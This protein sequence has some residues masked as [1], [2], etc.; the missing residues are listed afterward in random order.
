MQ[1]IFLKLQNKWPGKIARISNHVHYHEK[2]ARREA[3]RRAGVKG[4]IGKHDLYNNKLIKDQVTSA[5]VDKI[6]KELSETFRGYSLHCGG[7]VYYEDGIPEDLLMK[8]KH[9]R[10]I[11]N[12]I[13]QITHDKHSVSKEK[14]FKID[15]LSSR[16]L[17][18]LSEVYKS[19]FPGKQ[20]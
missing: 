9:E 18:Q 13:Q 4:F 5:K 7:I 1:Q 17:A 15:I 11:Y 6:T 16:G 10:R 12:T 19:V 3:L 14:R 8:D 2:S 20:I